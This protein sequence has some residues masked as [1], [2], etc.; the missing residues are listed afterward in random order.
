MASSSSSRTSSLLIIDDAD[1]GTSGAPSIRSRSRWSSSSVSCGVVLRRRDRRVEVRSLVEVGSSKSL[2]T[3]T[4]PRAAWRPAAGTMS[5]TSPPKRAI[6]RISF[7]ARNELP[8]ADGMK[9]VWT[10]EIVWF[11]WAIC[12]SVS[13]SET[14]RRPLTMKSAPTLAGQVDDQAGEH[15]DLDVVEVGDRLLD[16]LLALVEGEQR[17][18]LLRVAHGRDDDLVEQARRGLDD[19]E[20]AVVDRVE[21]SGIQDC[22]H[23][24]SGCGRRAQ[25][26]ASGDDDERTAVPPSP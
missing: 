12:S 11:I 25:D 18:A 21:R 20:V 10:P 24:D 16:H 5:E 17:L 4:S 19:L 23:D 2:M 13:K 8:D 22:G 7:E 6:S 14:A 9:S 15:R 3:G 1:S 26:G